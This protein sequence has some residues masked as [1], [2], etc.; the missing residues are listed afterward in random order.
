M[1]IIPSKFIGIRLP[2]EILARLEKIADNL[3]QTPNQLAKIAILEWIES[4]W[5]RNSDM[6][7]V[8]RS[9]YAKLLEMLKE[10]Q[11]HSFI[12]N[13]AESII[14]YYEYSIQKNANS[15]N[16]EEFITTMSKFIGEK[17]GLRWFRQMDYEVKTPPFNF[18]GTHDMGKKWS[19]IFI[20]IFQQILT[21]RSFNFDIVSDKTICSERI[22]YIEFQK[23]YLI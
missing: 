4:Y 5:T 11:L 8:N 2:E 3:N 7:T 12:S 19:D 21:K 14:E 9:S 13:I 16:L 23:K 15:S 22:V 18:K 20:G 17:T 1:I 10:V 6:I